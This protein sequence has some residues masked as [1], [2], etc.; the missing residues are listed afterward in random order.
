MPDTAPT[1]TPTISVVLPNLNGVRFLEGALESFVRQDHPAKELVVV[2]GGSTDGSHDV[3]AA[4]AESFAFVRWVRERDAGLSDAINRGVEHAT[5][6]LIGYQGGDDRLLPGVLSTVATLWGATPFDAVYFDAYNYDV[7]RHTYRLR[8][9]P[10]VA[11][12]RANLIRH[13]PIAGLHHI[14][15]RAEILRANRFDVT[16]RYS[17]DYELFHRIVDRHPAFVH[18]PVPGMVSYFHD[19]LTRRAGQAQAAEVHRVAQRYARTP[20]ER[21]RVATRRALNAPDLQQRV[22]TVL[23]RLRG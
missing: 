12:T 10:D 15:I 7:D 5:G 23:R 14:F 22:R 18:V 9:A 8:R 17:M 19:N 21:A 11:F 4:Y 13:G 20:A 6:E 1:P 2:D 3:I 16:N